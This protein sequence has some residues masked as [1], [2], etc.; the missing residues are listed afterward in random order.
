LKHADSAKPQTNAPKPQNALDSFNHIMQ[1]TIRDNPLKRRCQFS[2]EQAREQQVMGYL[3]VWKVLEEIIT[4]FRKK[5]LPIPATVMND[6][7]SAR[8]MIKIMDAD[9]GHG[10][11]RQ[12]IEE[13]LGTVEAYLVT[14]AEKHF[15]AERIDK[16]LKRLEIA[17]CETCEENAEESRFIAGV[18]RD[19]K[20][21]RVEP[22]AILPLEKL[23]QLAEETNL[24]ASTQKD[25]RVVVY[26]RAEDL[27]E[28]VKKM[29]TETNKE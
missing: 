12:K 15:A 26:G 17:N 19:Q 9:T 8:T 16:W 22:L 24:S 3:A 5:G 18:P 29:T 21:I 13:Y 14:G 7:K 10:E 25:G 23:R 6:L 27:K 1:L 28:F 20:W 2:F 4:E 11:S